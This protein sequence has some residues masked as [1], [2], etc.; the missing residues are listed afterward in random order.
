MYFNTWH[1]NVYLNTYHFQ[2]RRH[3][4]KLCEIKIPKRFLYITA[5]SKSMEATYDGNKHSL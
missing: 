1:S 5:L 4:I 2:R 3:V